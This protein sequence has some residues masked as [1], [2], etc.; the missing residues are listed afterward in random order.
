MREN[1]GEDKEQEEKEM[2]RNYKAE[3]KEEEGG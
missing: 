3:D 1:E 2:D